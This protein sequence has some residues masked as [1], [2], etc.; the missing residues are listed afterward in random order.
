MKKFSILLSIIVVAIVTV[1][2]VARAHAQDATIDLSLSTIPINPEPLQQV[3]ITAQSYSADLNQAE[4]TW[5]Y[6]GKIIS[7]GTGVTQVTVT[8]PASGSIGNI[9][10]TA[11]GGE[12]QDTTTNLILRPGS[13]DLLWEGVQSY[14]PP[15][16]KGRALP[17][18]DGI[19]RVTAVPTISAP[20][21]LSYTWTKNQDAQQDQSGYNKSD[22]VFQNNDLS[23][24]D[25]IDVT[26]ASGSFSGSATV[27]INP[28]DPYVA[29]YF[30]NNGFIDYSNG[31]TDSLTTSDSGAIVHFE[32]FF[33]PIP[34]G[35]PSSLNFSYTDNDGNT[36]PTQTP[37]NELSLASP[38]GGGVSQF[39]V[40]ISTIQY[41]LE[42]LTK[43]FSVNFN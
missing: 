16:Y 1:A 21:N 37:I 8:A 11:S 17:T 43:N 5:T 38:S 24:D 36:L 9:G 27:D 32:P 3:T 26:E 29:E 34:K 2:L 14:T 41:S 40:A 39:S 15:F 22:L 19:I 18:Q 6:N 10:V 28:V 20:A 25:E 4:M 31:S 30:N 42:N 35:F 33:F 23:P 7:E 13:V 12:F